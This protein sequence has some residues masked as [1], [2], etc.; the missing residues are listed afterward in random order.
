M[1]RWLLGRRTLTVVARTAPE[2]LH[3]SLHTYGGTPRMRR[4]ST[5]SIIAAAAA[6]VALVASPLAIQPAG[7]IPANDSTCTYVAPPGGITSAQISWYPAQPG[8]QSGLEVGCVL[9]HDTGSSLVSGAYTIHD[10]EKAMWHNG[11]AR[12]VTTSGVTASGSS[13][14]QLSTASNGVAG[15]PTGTVNRIISGHAG[16]AARVFVTSQTAGGLLTLNLPT[17]ASIPSGTALKVENATGART[18]VDGVT[19][20]TTT[21]TSATANFAASDVGLSIGGT[22][23]PAYTTIS[24]VV[25]ATTVTMSV[26]AIASNVGQTI[27][28][29]GTLRTTTVRQVSGLTTSSATRIV[30][31]GGFGGWLA[32]DLGLKVTGQCLN[33]ASPTTTI[34]ANTYV[35]ATPSQTNL[36]VTTGLTAGWTECTIV[37]GEANANAPVD[38]DVIAA[39]GV[40]LNLSP[41]LVAG[42]DA[43]SNEQPEGF[44]L[45]G[46]WYSPGNFQGVGLSNTPPTSTKAIGQL[47]FDTSAVD[48]SA[49]VIERKVDLAHPN[50]A[51]HYDVVF[52]FAPTGL[53]MCPISA[54]SPG[55]G[56]LLDLEPITATQSAS[57]SGTG[58][59]GTGQV[60][61]IESDGLGGPGYTTKVIV[62]SQGTPWVPSTSFERLCVYPA[63]P[64]PVNFQCGAG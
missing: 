31:T 35:T 20:G 22:D 15:M 23:I 11:A 34:P 26:A 5:R 39:Q 4:F 33:G 49:F 63:A 8:S 21:L 46:K 45:V 9:R 1:T 17:T 42:S 36:D 30:G 44:A 38:G 27:S 47:L 51:V 2:S 60:R 58:R 10:T 14:I 12:T 59:P 57:A 48:F 40:Q 54:T 50:I 61:N 64:S 55:L 53:A 62:D 19:N 6:A 32:T 16:L 41:S 56:F 24:A 13:T 37:L 18:V 43:C 52:P 7:A 3:F 28:I 25:N 29:G